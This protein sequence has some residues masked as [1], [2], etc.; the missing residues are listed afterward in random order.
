MKSKFFE[1]NNYKADRR[2]HRHRCKACNK[3]IKEGEPA[4][5][6]RKPNARQG[7]IAIHA[8]CGS[9]EHSP[10]NTFKERMRQWAGV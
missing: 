1:T 5:L 3:I 7:W 2:K 6:C 9:T 8:A 10:G 4:I